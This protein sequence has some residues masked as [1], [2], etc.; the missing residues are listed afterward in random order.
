MLTYFIWLFLKL[1]ETTTAHCGYDFGS[2]FP[3]S[4]EHS[5]HH[6]HIEN[7]Y[8]SFFNIWDRI[9]GTN[10]KFNK[11]EENRIEKENEKNK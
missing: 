8:G 10:S 7:N 9:L 4:R 11:F 3:N 1:F 6:S 5:Y 2:W